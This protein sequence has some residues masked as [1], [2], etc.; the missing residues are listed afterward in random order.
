MDSLIV[1][2]SSIVGPTLVL[3]SVTNVSCNGLTDGAIYTTGSGG[4]AP[5]VY[6]WNTGATS[7]DLIGLGEGSYVLTL[8]D[9]NGCTVTISDTVTQP[10]SPIAISAL[11]VDNICFGYATGTIDLTALG[12]TAPYQYQWNNGT[13]TQDL[14]TLLAGTYNVVVMDNNGCLIK[15]YI[16]LAEYG[17]DLLKFG[18]EV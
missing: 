17:M 11:I 13:F 14:T 9:D 18:A 10:A 4:V 6:S 16:S 1:N 15:A 7:E 3:D 2:V 12:G 5:L 8:T